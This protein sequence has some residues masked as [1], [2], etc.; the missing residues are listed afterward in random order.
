MGHRHVSHP[1][2]RAESLAIFP[3]EA[4]IFAAAWWFIWNRKPSAGMWGVAASVTWIL[5]WLI[6]YVQFRRPIWGFLAIGV[7][8]A[9]AFSWRDNTVDP[10]EGSEAG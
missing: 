6:S 1:L 3:V 7:I 5:T 10:A 8:G 2:V 4:A 9:I